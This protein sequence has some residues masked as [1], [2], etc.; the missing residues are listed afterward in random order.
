MGLAYNLGMPNWKSFSAIA[1]A[2]VLA[3]L[4]AFLY[5]RSGGS[6]DRAELVA[7]R[8]RLQLV[9]ARAQT[10][11]A[12]VSL[13]L[14]NFGD[15]GRHLAFA[16]SALTSAR[17]TLVSR[18]QSELVSKVDQAVK[19]LNT[20]QDQASRLNQDANSRAGEAA[21]LLNDIIQATSGL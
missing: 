7:T 19:E 11:D 12:R 21:R 14:V 16:R 15:A 10:L 5:G 20:A 6:V 8:L 17:V 1:M 13:Y 18:G 4:V 2:I 3:W 9:E